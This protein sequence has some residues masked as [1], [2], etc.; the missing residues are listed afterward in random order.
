MNGGLSGNRDMPVS[1]S[2]ILILVGMVVG[3]FFLYTLHLFNLQ[4]INSELY[5]RRAT[6]VTQRSIPIYAQ[7]GE[8]YDRHYDTPIVSNIDSFAVDIIPG[9]VP[10]GERDEL[11]R[12]LSPVLGL[13][14]EEIQRRIPPDFSNLYQ[15]VEIKSGI[16][17]ETITYIAEHLEEFPGITWRNKPIRNYVEKESLSH[18]LGYVG[19][20]TREELQVLYNRG[21]SYGSVLGKSG[22]ERQ[23][24]DLLRGNDGKRFRTVDVRGRK[25]GEALLEEISPSLGSNIVLTIDRHIQ[26]LSEKALGNRVGSIIVMKPATGEVLA[27][28]SYPSFDPNA[29]YD[30]NNT[31]AFRKLS[32]DTSFPFINRAIQS[33]YVPASAYKIILTTAIVEEEIFPTDKTVFCSGTLQV[34]DR[35]FR[36]HKQSGHGALSLD[37]ALAE[38]CNIYFY[39]LGGEYLGIERIVDFSRRFG[40]G[41][42]TGLDIPG[43]ISGTL[44]SPAWKSRT[45]NSRWVGGDTVN[46]SIGQ[47]FLLVTPIQMATAVSLI[48]NNGVVYKPHFLKEVRD[49]VSGD[50]LEKIEPEVLISSTIRDSSFKHVQNAMR[51]VITGGTAK[52]VITTNAVEVAGKTG[53][54]EF[55]VEN[56]WHSWFVSYAPFETDDPEERIVL[57]VMVEAVNEWEWWAPKASNIILHGIFSKMTYEEV[58]GS[59]RTWYL[60]ADSQ[61]ER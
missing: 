50:L 23:Y 15:P 59:L 56:H 45:F 36:C 4:I 42:R 24:D 54:G 31:E 41:E 30:S 55:G 49:P 10:I 17:L 8:I 37:D 58:L 40:L 12:S 20:I 46:M 14:V 7:R 21:Y 26:K 13:S 28:V 16:S 3:V 32:L 48:V 61:G 27:M 60:R 1:K 53:T 6:Q 18:V 35:A 39:T 11:F 44:P 29:F 5:Q 57:V 34:G 33:Q 47:G 19:D 52:V 51:K 25:V 38:S 22:I 43:E 2:R 9:E